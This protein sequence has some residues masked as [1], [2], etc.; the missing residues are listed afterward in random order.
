MYNVIL[1]GG[2]IVLLFMFYNNSMV[3]TNTILCMLSNFY[4]MFLKTSA[5]ISKEFIFKDLV[6][7]FNRIFFLIILCNKLLKF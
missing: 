3:A 1:F 5:N 7:I 4:I 6:I 2:I